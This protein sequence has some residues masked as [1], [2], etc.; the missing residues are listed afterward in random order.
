VQAA[1]VDN[2][3][4][5]LERQRPSSPCC[6]HLTDA[7]TALRDEPE[8]MPLEPACQPHLQGEE[9]W[10]RDL[11]PLKVARRRVRTQ[12]RDDR[13][14]ELLHRLPEHGFLVHKPQA[15]AHPLRAVARGHKRRP[16][17]V[18]AQ[19][20]YE[21]TRRPAQGGKAL[22]PLRQRGTLLA[23][24]DGAVGNVVVRQIASLAQEPGR[25]PRGSAAGLRA[26]SSSGARGGTR[27]RRRDPDVSKLVR[28]AWGMVPPNPNALT[29]SHLSA[30]SGSGARTGAMFREVKSMCG[31]GA[32]RCAFREHGDGVGRAAP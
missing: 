28:T 13:V 23:L 30:A 7:V 29:T 4:R 16:G 6:H 10:L 21:H 5:V 8:V 1:L 27:S 18:W 11:R 15:T 3:D 19:A 26:D 22:E 17:G 2:P 31:L 9:G 14:A 12:R 20:A 32:P 24:Q 25:A